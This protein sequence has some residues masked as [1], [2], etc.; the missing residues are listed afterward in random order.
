P[1]LLTREWTLSEEEQGWGD[2]VLSYLDT[3]EI[4]REARVEREVRIDLRPLGLDGTDF[5]T[6]D[7]VAYATVSLVHLMDWKFGWNEVDDVEV[8]YQFQI[9]AL[10]IFYANPRVREV[11]VHMVQ[12]KLDL[13]D[14]HTFHRHDIDHLLERVT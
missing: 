2:A 7:R 1:G 6:A 14:V 11:R 13:L 8:N 5:G 10:G 3:V 9:Y 12:P 4:P